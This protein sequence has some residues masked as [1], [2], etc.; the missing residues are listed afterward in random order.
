MDQK[1]TLVELIKRFCGCLTINES[2]PPYGFENLAE[3]LISNGVAIPIQCKDCDWFREQD[4]GICVNPK[5][6]KSF[7]G[8]PV[9]EDHFCSYGEPRKDENVCD[10]CFCGSY[11]SCAGCAYPELKENK[12]GTKDEKV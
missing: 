3:Y 10:H 2:Q 11:R 5:A 12:Y 1:G 9:P 8:C 7:Y 6:T 4:G